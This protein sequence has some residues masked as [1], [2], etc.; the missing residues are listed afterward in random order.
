MSNINHFWVEWPGNDR[1]GARMRWMSAEWCEWLENDMNACGMRGMRLEWDGWHRMTGKWCEWVSNDENEARMR[2]MTKND[3][4]MMGMR[5]EW[6]G[7]HRMTG[8]WCEWV[9][10]EGNEARMR[11][12][13]VEW[14]E[15]YGLFPPYGRWV[16]G[17]SGGGTSHPESLWNRWLRTVEWCE[18][19]SNDMNESKMRW[20]TV[21]W[22][23]WYGLF[24]PYGR[25][26]QGYSGG[27][28]NHP[29]SLWS[30]WWMTLEWS[31][32]SHTA[33]FP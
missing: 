27:G 13:T 30:R 22:C 21:E 11:W 5:L 24:P 20:M 25:W 8:K 28:T 19:Q 15:W 23:E 4:K 31:G 32:M 7:W 12:M 6:D 16:Q 26:V 18:W 9:S 14:C 3:W 1:N 17:Y 2:W 33:V 29:E 10:N